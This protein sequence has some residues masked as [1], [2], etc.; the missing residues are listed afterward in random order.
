MGFGWLRSCLLSG[1]VV[2]FCQVPSDVDH[3]GLEAALLYYPLSRTL[4]LA[5]SKVRIP[6]Y[7]ETREPPSQTVAR[8]ATPE[9]DSD[10]LCE[11]A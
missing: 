6:R 3:G 5:S 1:C 4:V 8:F 11:L 10:G 7:T 9:S 2:K